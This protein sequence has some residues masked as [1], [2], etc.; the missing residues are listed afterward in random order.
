MSKL[1]N[2]ALWEKHTGTLHTTLLLLL[3]SEFV[4][5]LRMQSYNKRDKTTTKATTT[6]MNININSFELLFFYLFFGFFFTFF[7]QFVLNALL[8]HIATFYLI[9]RFD[10]FRLFFISFP[11]P[12]SSIVLLFTAAIHCQCKYSFVRVFTF[13]P[14]RQ[15]EIVFDCI[16]RFSC[17]IECVFFFVSVGR[18]VD[19]LSL[20]LTPKSV[21]S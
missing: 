12:Y 8:L 6:M 15:F 7:S 5:L 11:R 4:C 2:K 19:W 16:G 20:L 18:S 10:K 14:P 13:L 3:M 1:K 17:G 21:S 9:R